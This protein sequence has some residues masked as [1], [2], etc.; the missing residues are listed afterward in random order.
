MD[1]EPID[2]VFI[3]SGCQHSSCLESIR[4]EIFFRMEKKD[5][6]PNRPVDGCA[7]TISD[8]DITMVLTDDEQ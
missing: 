6:T 4:M 2:N 8:A 3:V 5:V 1:D 7:A